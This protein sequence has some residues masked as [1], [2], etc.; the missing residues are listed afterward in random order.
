MKTSHLDTNRLL[1]RPFLPSDAQDVQR[2]AGDWSIADTTLN[3]PHPYEDGMAERWISTHQLNSDSGELAV[4]AIVTKAGNDLV[5]AIS[6]ELDQPFDRGRLGYWIGKP[7]WG[8]GYCTEAADRVLCFGFSE[9]GLN[10]IH[11]AHLKRNPASGRV[12]QKIGMREEGVA[13]Q[14]VKKW[15]KFEDLV[16]YGILRDDKQT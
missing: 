7:Y 14:H 13:R 8:L 9:L 2:L 16:F 5:G 10:R 3:V 12:M 15:G 6:L 4:F 11:S 1:L